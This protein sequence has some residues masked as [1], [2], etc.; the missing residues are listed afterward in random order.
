MSLN[1]SDS[2]IEFLTV[3]TSVLQAAHFFV[4]FL[5]AFVLCVLCVVALVLARSLN[6]WIRV[7][8]I[9]VFAAQICYWFGMSLFYLGHPFRAY[10]VEYISC[11]IAYSVL[12]IATT[13]VSRATTLYA[14]VVYSFVK[15]GKN[16]F[17]WCGMSLFIALSWIFALLVSLVPYFIGI[18]ANT[19]TLLGFCGTNFSTQGFLAASAFQLV[20]H[21]L[22]L[23]GI[24]VFCALIFHH[25]KKNTLEDNDKVKGAIIKNLV[26]LAATTLLIFLTNL[27]SLLSVTVVP[28]LTDINSIL[29]VNFLF[30]LVTILPSLAIPIMTIVL[31]RP[32]RV[33]LK[34]MF[35]TCCYRKNGLSDTQE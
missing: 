14:G 5:P 20:T 17:K 23:C 15:Y 3:I 28:S 6:L 11:F 4:I 24:F 32:V 8:L 22:C 33:A 30:P 31:L 26:F 16:R 12:R 13:M 21:A 35:K 29:L 34:H 10:H 25:M 7:S 2:E 1:I 9:N 19:R 18:D 27:V